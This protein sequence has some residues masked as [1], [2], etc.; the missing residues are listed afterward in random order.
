MAGQPGV[1][2]PQ[3]VP[4]PQP[5]VVYQT[6]PTSM[7]AY[8]G[9]AMEG[10]LPQGA[11]MQGAPMYGAPMYG[12]PMDPNAAPGYPQSMPAETYG[13]WTGADGCSGGGG[14]DDCGDLSC[15]G[16]CGD[17]FFSKLLGCCGGL[18]I[19]SGVPHPARVW[20][21]VEYLLW[22]NSDRSVPVLATTS[23]AGTPF[24]EAGVLGQPSTSILFGGGEYDDD[25]TS[26][27][28]GTL[29]LWID[30]NQT[31][32]VFGRA[33][34][35][36]AE[37]YNF[38]A[39]SSGSPILARPFFNV[40]TGLQD[41]LVVAYPGLSRGRINV[42]TENTMQGF[43]LLL[44]KMLY[45]GECNR[46]DFIGGYQSTQIDDS[47]RV[48]H[49]LISEDP[50][51]R[52]PVGTRID[53]SDLFEAENEFHGGVIGLMAQGFDGRF[54]WNLMTKV[55]FGNTKESLSIR[56]TSTTTIP[57]AGSATS[58][59]GL[60][61]LN[62]NQGIYEQDEFTVVPELDLS[63]MYQLTSQL[64]MSV[65]YSAL[66]WTNAVMAGEAIDLNINPTQIDGQLL[67]PAQPNYTLADTEFWA[68]GLTFGLHGRF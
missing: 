41:A 46:I 64:Q 18:G 4:A 42:D 51:G 43:D 33:Y 24:A 53:T 15:Q 34:Q 27:V 55:A 49:M 9:G 5:S 22:W 56:G 59:Q 23:V 63:V 17:G 36:G 40:D 25:P 26:G 67:G 14:C 13:G 38:V 3:A 31:L 68:Q 20:G 32:G 16:G 21:S 54:T 62:T 8:T 47:V 29:G 57:G 50:Q 19:D 2:V 1:P 39:E 45:Y 44:R 65:G 52:V 48:S 28:R 11:P 6:A 10:G 60:L 7:P 12:Q 35:L 58:N 30:R 37:D 66:F 61:A